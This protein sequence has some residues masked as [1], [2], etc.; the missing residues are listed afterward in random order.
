MSQ[1][2]FIAG[3]SGSGKTALIPH[4]EKLFGNHVSI[5]DFDDRG[6]PE[7]ADKKWR[8]ETTEKWL[9]KLLRDDKKACLIGQIILGELLACPSAKQI[10]N[11]NF[12]LLDVSDFE[13]N[14]RLKKRNIYG[15]DQNMLNWSAWLRMHHQDP[16]WMQHVIKKN[17]WEGLNFS[18]WDQLENW[19][20]RKNSEILDTTDLTSP[21]VALS[22]YDWIHKTSN[23]KR[24][25]I[26]HTPYVLYK[27]LK[28]TFDIIDTKLFAYNKQCVPA[29]QNPENIPI[30]YV[31][32]ENDTII[33]GICAS[34]YTWKIMHIDLLFVEKA[35]RT[36]NL[37]SLLLRQ[38]EK[39]AKIMG[40]TLIHLSTF[41]F[42]AKDFYVKH[43]YEIFG[44][45]DD[46]PQGYKRYSLKKVL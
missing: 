40:V 25:N 5:H 46:C 43:N 35:Y 17:S 29:T 7:N 28:N 27:N 18:S 24:E 45:L 6:V 15:A 36:Q 9:Q 21:Q 4:L 44:V 11:V 32:K 16:Q 22:V 14:Q 26:P 38:V 42:Q 19:S 12:C 8:Q 20:N 2:Y 3:A 34:I 23:Q 33:A 31:I 30:H 37:G 1:L 41:E 13:R 39:E 10:D